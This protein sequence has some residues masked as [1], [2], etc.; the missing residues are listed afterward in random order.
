MN[1]L[2]GEESYDR[3]QGRRCS[4]ERNH[5]R[6]NMIK[7][8][9]RPGFSV[10]F[11]LTSGEVLAQKLIEGSFFR[12]AKLWRQKDSW[13]RSSQHHPMIFRFGESAENFVMRIAVS[14]PRT[15]SS[16]ESLAETQRLRPAERDVWEFPS[17]EFYAVIPTPESKPKCRRLSEF[18]SAPGCCFL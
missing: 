1:P 11:T 7:Y 18:I 14:H 8:H 4:S 6:D 15:D 12:D 10:N 2:A 16:N 13:Q 17:F 3:G 9:N 5:E